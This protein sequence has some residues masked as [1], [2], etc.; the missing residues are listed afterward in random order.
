MGALKIQLL[1]T[2]Q[3]IMDATKEFIKWLEARIEYYTYEYRYSEDVKVREI[4]QI[5]RTEAQWILQKIEENLR[6]ASTQAE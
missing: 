1:L 5:K 6:L 4:I 2:N 3:F